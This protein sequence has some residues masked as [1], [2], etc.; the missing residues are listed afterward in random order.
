MSGAAAAAAEGVV[1]LDV[2]AF[3]NLMQSQRFIP[4]ESGRYWVAISLREVA[5]RLVL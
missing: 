3:T 2:S 4:A 5:P 1:E